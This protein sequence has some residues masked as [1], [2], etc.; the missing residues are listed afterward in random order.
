MN[1]LR[2]VRAKIVSEADI[3]TELAL[4]AGD[5]VI[6][7]WNRRGLVRSSMCLRALGDLCI[8]RARELSSRLVE[9]S[10]PTVT[11]SLGAERQ[12]ITAIQQ[13]VG[14]LHDRFRT[15]VFSV[16]VRPTSGSAFQPL[17]NQIED[18]IDKVRSSVRSNLDFARLGTARPHALPRHPA[19]QS[20][21]RKRRHAYMLF[22]DLCGSTGMLLSDFS[23]GVHLQQR[24]ARLCAKAA[25]L[26]ENADRFKAVG[27]GV[28]IEF[29]EALAAC[30][31]ALA[32]LSECR[33]VRSRAKRDSAL[34]ELHAKVAVVEGECVS[35]EGTQRWLGT[36][37]TK[38]ARYSSYARVD[39]AWIDGETANVIQSHLKTLRA[40]C[41]TEPAGGCAFRVSPKGL[42]SMSSS[43]HL[44]RPVSSAIP[45]TK[46]EIEKV[47]LLNWND[48]ET[49]AKDLVEQVHREAFKPTRVVGIGRSGA[50]LAGMIAGNLEDKAVDG[51][52]LPVDAIDRRLRG[53]GNEL[54]GVSRF[55]GP[56]EV[57]RDALL[58]SKHGQFC[59]RAGRNERLLV[60]VG[61]AKSGRSF[62]AAKGWLGRRGISGEKLL[63]ACVLRGTDTTVD[64]FWMNGESGLFP[65]QFKKGYDRGWTAPSS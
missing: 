27:D 36:L 61:E 32:I 9:I 47:W 45:L 17:L 18:R 24:H 51:K 50:I 41:E 12:L 28:M 48:L 53:K 33:K 40:A 35:A 38:A 34:R 22:S 25:G 13:S 39:Q 54:R 42:R 15:R 62:S 2:V 29:E 8:D 10:A 21:G 58:V 1:R 19:H 43:I 49:A 6:E 16:V 4:K 5:Q 11:A 31:C 30:K 60:V 52:H 56:E 20:S 26:K 7:D 46:D 64:L 44:L 57:Y 23:S 55:M 3:L 59:R 65:W 14:R 37:P 63:T